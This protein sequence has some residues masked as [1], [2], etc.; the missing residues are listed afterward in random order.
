MN[1]AKALP[2][3]I[4][5]TAWN[6]LVK[7]QFMYGL[8]YMAAQFP[9]VHKTAITVNYRLLKHLFNLKATVSTDKF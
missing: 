9:Q 3:R 7:S 6:A 8:H 5:W 1:W 4:K 2:Q